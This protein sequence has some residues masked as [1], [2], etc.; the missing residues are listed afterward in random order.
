[1]E[2]KQIFEEGQMLFIEGKVKES[3][4]AFSKAIEAGAD[5]F[6]AHLS[7]GAAYLRLRDV[8]R[9]NRGLQPLRGHKP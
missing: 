9:G 2:A 4:E 7:R 8:D 5:P 3:V 1:M 6:M